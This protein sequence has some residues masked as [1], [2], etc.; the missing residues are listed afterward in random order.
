MTKNSWAPL[1]ALACSISASLGYAS[2]ITTQSQTS[3]DSFVLSSPQMING[4]SL[5]IT[6]TCDG[7]SISP[8]LQWSG[9]PINTK[10]YALIMH[11]NAPDGVHWY[12]TMYNIDANASGLN[13]DQTQGKLGTNSVNDLNEYAPPCSKGPG[14]KDYTY[15]VYALSAPV[16]FNDEQKVNRATLLAAIKNTTLDSASMTLSY[17]RAKN[18]TK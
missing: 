17:Q 15:T 9:A 14:Q 5:P 7:D 4:G 10:Y 2:S 8:P 16:T 18:V 11:H 3:T 1:L 13:S 12:W 6:Y